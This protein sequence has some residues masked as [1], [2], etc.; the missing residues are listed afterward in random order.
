VI[1]IR[2]FDP[3][4]QFTDSFPANIAPTRLRDAALASVRR[5]QPHARFRPATP[6]TEVFIYRSEFAKGQIARVP[7]LEITVPLHPQHSDRLAGVAQFL[8]EG[9]SVV[10]E[11]ARLDRRLGG[12]AGLAFVVAGGLLA[13][14]LWPA[15]RRMERLAQE[16]AA[17]SERLRRANEELALTAR[18]AALGAVSAHLMHGLKNPLASLSQFVHSGSRGELQQEDWQDALAAARRMHSLVEQTLEVLAEAGSGASYTLTA[19]ELAHQ[20]QARVAALAQTRAVALRMEADLQDPLPSH[21]ANLISL[22]LVNLLENA[23]QATPAGKQV[24]LVLRAEPDRLCWRVQDQGPGFPA[25]LRSSLFLP[26]QST[27][28]GGS[29][30][31]LAISKQLANHLGASL[32]LVEPAEGGCI[33]ELAVPRTAL[34]DGTAAATS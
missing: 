11:Y 12:L 7:V 13:V 29:G 1:G 24:S 30:L 16:V 4:G 8:V 18:A 20:V 25:H 15:F 28:E 10:E 22:I 26:C 14:M 5:F 33:F 17:R 27:R 23:I 21:T 34:S 19:A 31:G 3:G 32:E 2:F 6:L 9:Y